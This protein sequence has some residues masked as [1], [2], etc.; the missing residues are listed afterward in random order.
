MTLSFSYWSPFLDNVQNKNKGSISAGGITS[1]RDE[2]WQKRIKEFK[3]SPFFGVG[4]ATVSVEESGS[5]FNKADGKVETGSSWLNILS[6]TGIFGFICFIS[7]WINNFFLLIRLYRYNIYYSSYLSALL[8]FWCLH[9][10]AE[11]YIFA[12][13]GFLFFCVWLLLGYIYILGKYP[14]Y[15]LT[16][17]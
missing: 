17:R 5:T 2:H 16:V 1:S 14:H 10:I 8:I 3:S 4:F 13:G 11:G 6:M 15:L 12:A 9:M 7:L